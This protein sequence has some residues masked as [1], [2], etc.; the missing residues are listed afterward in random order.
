VVVGLVL[1]GW[2]SARLGEA[3]ARR[4]IIRNVGVGL[5][6]MLVTYFVGKL[7]GVTLG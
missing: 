7:F 1:A 2:I 3:D 4:A 5:L 6:A